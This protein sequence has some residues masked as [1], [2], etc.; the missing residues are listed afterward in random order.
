[1]SKYTQADA[2][3]D[4]GA[5]SQQVSQAWHDARDDAASDSGWGVPADRHGEG[6]G[7]IGSIANAIGNIFGGNKDKD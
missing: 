6:G 7:I 4:T 3:R 2:A 1:M 5:T